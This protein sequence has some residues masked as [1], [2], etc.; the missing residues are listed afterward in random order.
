MTEVAILLVN[1]FNSFVNTVLANVLRWELVLVSC[2]NCKGNCIVHMVNVLLCPL[3]KVT[4]KS[5]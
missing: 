4:D 3:S 1:M 2:A 5:V